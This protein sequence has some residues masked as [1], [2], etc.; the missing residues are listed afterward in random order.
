M[1]YKG[2]TKR[3]FFVVRIQLGSKYLHF[4]IGKRVN[5]GGIIFLDFT[6]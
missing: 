4:Y 2:L 6:D 5:Q 3:L 1:R